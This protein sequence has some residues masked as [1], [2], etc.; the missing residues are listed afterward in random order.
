[1][2]TLYLYILLKPKPVL[3]ILFNLSSHHHL[4]LP[5]CL[6]EKGILAGGMVGEAGHV[7]FP[8]AR[9]KVVFL[10]QSLVS[11][12][13]VVDTV[14]CLIIVLFYWKCNFLMKPHVRLLVGWPISLI[15]VSVGLS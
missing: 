2:N 4:Q 1:M 11:H 14:K 10:L 3:Y 13:F 7:L 8:S 15:G 12:S 9:L 6:V 5:L